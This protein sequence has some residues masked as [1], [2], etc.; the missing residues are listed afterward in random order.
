MDKKSLVGLGAAVFFVSF[1]CLAMPVKAES[2]DEY[3]RPR[4]KWGA[5]K[6]QKF[7]KLIQKL[8]LSEE[9]VAR[10]KEHK[11]AK[12]ESR[13]KLYAQLGEHKQALKDELEKP[14]SDNARIKQIA[15]SIKQVQSEMVDERIKG[16]LEIKAILTPEQYSEFKA[17]IRRYKEKKMLG[18]KGDKG[19]DAWHGNPKK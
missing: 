1:L 9:Q 10:L 14:A 7:D 3:C 2:G 17:N 19:P 11:Q 15:D 8:D 5:E 13:E 16:I 12:M 6:Q 4:Q 18:R